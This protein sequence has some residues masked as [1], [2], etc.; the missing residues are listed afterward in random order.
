[1]SRR[2]RITATE[3][4]E[5]SVCERRVLLDRLR[6]KRRTSQSL[7]EMAAGEAVHRRLD[8]EAQQLLQ[9]Q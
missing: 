8:R 5:C 4:A 6:G 9:G 3:L 2:R 7:A 1:M